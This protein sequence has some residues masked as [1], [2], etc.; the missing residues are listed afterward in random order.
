MSHVFMESSGRAARERRRTPGPPNPEPAL[1]STMRHGARAMKGRGEKGVATATSSGFRSAAERAGAAGSRRRASGRAAGLEA[2]ES[3]STCAT[4]ARHD[5]PRPTEPARRKSVSS[6]AP[7][8]RESPK[9]S[10]AMQ[11]PS[12][13]GSTVSSRRLKASGKPSRRREIEVRSPARVG[14]PFSQFDADVLRFGEEI[15]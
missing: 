11:S 6:C 14:L 3:E 4:R 8:V 9:S 12:K 1:V 10:H 2:F 15:E 13:G 7:P 5:P